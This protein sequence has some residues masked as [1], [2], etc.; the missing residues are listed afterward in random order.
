M[1]YSIVARDRAT[2]EMGI[3]VQSHYPA[4]GAVVPWAAAGVACR[5]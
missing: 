2:G 1:T 5:E 3:A 4:S